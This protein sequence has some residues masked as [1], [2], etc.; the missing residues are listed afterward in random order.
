MVIS[1]RKQMCGEKSGHA[2]DNDTRGVIV[3]FPVAVQTTLIPE[4]VKD[5][6]VQRVRQSVPRSCSS[7][8]I[9]YARFVTV[10]VH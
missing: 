7:R 6:T 9:Y 2:V 3:H 8:Q 10:V 1:R 4:V 5:C